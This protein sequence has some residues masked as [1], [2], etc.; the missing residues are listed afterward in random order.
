MK[1]IFLQRFIAAL[2]SFP[3]TTQQKFEKQLRFL[4]ENPR[5][6]S[7]DLKKYDESR[8]IWQARVDLY[9]RFYFLIE[10]DCYIMLHIRKHPK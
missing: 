9:H 7:L 3:L 5:H 4:L 6:P 10:G 1:P 8:G 2:E